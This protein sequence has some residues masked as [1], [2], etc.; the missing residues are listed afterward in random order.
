M[1]TNRDKRRGMA[2]RVVSG[3]DTTWRI[4]L[5]YACYGVTTTGNIVT[6]TPPIARWMIGKSAEAVKAW[7]C[8]KSGTMEA[9][10]CLDFVTDTYMI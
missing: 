5:P 7:V 6:D 3:S 10:E 8:R 9:V 4:D 1:N 2:N